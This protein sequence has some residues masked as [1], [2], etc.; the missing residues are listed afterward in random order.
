MRNF[1]LGML[2]GVI[3]GSAVYGWA[4]DVGYQSH[5]VNPYAAGSFQSDQ[6]RYLD[7]L[8]RQTDQYLSQRGLGLYQRPCP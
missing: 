1:I 4:G 2:S 8:D 5:D 6:L 7:S 3:L